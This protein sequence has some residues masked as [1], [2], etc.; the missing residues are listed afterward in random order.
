MTALASGFSDTFRSLRVR[1]FRLFFVGQFVSQTGTWMTMVALNLL[2]LELTG[3]GV[4][5]GILAACQFGP[6]LLFGAFA[7]TLADRYDKRRLMLFTQVGALLQSLV[8]GIVIAT[9]HGSLGVLYPLVAVRGVL[10]ALDNP[11]R[12]AFV[13][14]MVPST[15]MA[16][17]VSLSSTVQTGSRAIGPA[18]AGV[19]VLLVGYAWCFFLDALSY[20]AVIGGL[21]A[22]RRSELFP[23]PPA[24]RVRRQTREGLRYIA[25]NRDLLIPL[26]MMTIIGVFALNFSVTTP[27]LVTGPLGAS[28][29][30]YTLVYSAMALAAVIGALATAHHHVTQKS[31]LTRAMALF[32]V[33]MFVLG[34]APN[35]WIAYLG[36]LMV[37]FGSTVFMTSAT[38]TVQLLSE[39]RYRGRVLAIQAMV[40]VGSTPIG[41][42]LVGW[43]ADTLG[44]RA[45]VVVGGVA[46]F[47][48]AVWAHSAWKRPVPNEPAMAEMLPADAPEFL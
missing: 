27:L 41:G 11:S 31:R 37:G 13:V 43:V 6:V 15:H 46:C 4:Q 40:F 7:G 44:A 9:G 12:R 25:S 26:V 23:T 20:V 1:N 48:A 36:A 30:T 33:G 21:L 29:Q 8:V 38:A 19:L 16:N 14:E 17:A 45:S 32:G 24:P 42:P 18:V 39:P 5:L 28:E 47:A 22:M 34:L 2:V 35:L 10:T 3:S